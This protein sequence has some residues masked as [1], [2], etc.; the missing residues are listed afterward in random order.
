MLKRCAAPRCACFACVSL[1]LRMLRVREPCA[2][3]CAPPAAPAARQTC[4][5]C[6]TLLSRWERV[7]ALQALASRLSLPLCLLCLLRCQ[8]AAGMHDVGW[9]MLSFCICLLYF[10]GA[11]VG[12]LPSVAL[13]QVGPN[14][15]TF[16]CIRLHV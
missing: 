4:F 7:L 1:A 12:I 5:P 10:L 6:Y 11:Q 16:H 8:V 9:S 15:I 13:W 2:V 14:H 3:R